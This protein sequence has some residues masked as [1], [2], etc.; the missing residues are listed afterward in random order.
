MF[1]PIGT[2]CF[3][4]FFCWDFWCGESKKLFEQYWFIL[5][6][7][8]GVMF[9]IRQF[10]AVFVGVG[11]LAWFFA[12]P[13]PS[14]RG[15]SFVLARTLLLVGFFAVGDCAGFC[16]VARVG[17]VGNFPLMFAALEFL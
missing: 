12:Q 7:F 4:L 2:V 9:G 8:L 1:P 5:G 11:L 14:H 6:F 3:Y 16:G 15:S 10:T 17:D 13:P